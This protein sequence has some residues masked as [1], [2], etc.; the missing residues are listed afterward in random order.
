MIPSAT[1]YHEVQL[2]VKEDWGRRGDEWKRPPLIGP[3]S[4]AV[5]IFKLFIPALHQYCIRFLVKQKQPNALKQ[6]QA[7]SN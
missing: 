4:S 1:F 3:F 7:H 2:E 6:D 5:N